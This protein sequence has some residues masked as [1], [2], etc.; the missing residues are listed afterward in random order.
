MVSGQIRA[1]L[2]AQPRRWLVT[3][4]AGFIGS[5]LLEALLALDQSVIGLDNFATGPERNLD[6]V[7]GRTTPQRWSRFE[8]V[9]GDIRTSPFERG[10]AH[11]SSGRPRLGAAVSRRSIDHPRRQCR[12]LREHAAGGARA[13]GAKNV[14]H[15]QADISK[16]AR[17]LGYKPWARCRSEGGHALVHRVL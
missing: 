6:E 15:S 14:R 10:S 13:G 2:Q 1:V 4:A 16:A 3:G 5:N 17:L 11:T 12:W 7:R 9:E 8:F